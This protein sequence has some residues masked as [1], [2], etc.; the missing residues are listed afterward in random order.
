M[1]TPA[2]NALYGVMGLTVT[3]IYLATLVIGVLLV[4]T[5]SGDRAA[6]WGVRCGVAVSL[7]GMSV[8][9]LMVAKGGHAVGVPDGGPGLPLVGW[10]TTGGDLRVAHFAGMHALQLL[11][12]A[13]G[14]LAARRVAAGTALRVVAVL[15]GLVG[16]W[17]FNLTY[18]PGP[19]GASYVQA[20]F[21]NPATSSVAVDVL[22]TA[23]AASV[24][25]VAEGRRIG[26]R[27][28]WVLV[29]LTFAVALAATFPLFL[30]LRERHLSA[31]GRP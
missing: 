19:G 23:V 6:D 22:V 29:P 21:A 4:A 14:V 26:M 13:A 31:S 9:V 24:F 1:D 3:V 28:S 12:L 10:S 15:A 2:D 27:W 25:Y 7:L 20:W 8:G 5:P 16:T 30:A 17:Y 18:R 11:P